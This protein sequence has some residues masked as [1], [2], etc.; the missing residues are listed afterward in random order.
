V[1]SRL[2]TNG[3]AVDVLVGS[4]VGDGIGVNV[5]IG[6]ARVGGIAVLV[7]ASVTGGAMVVVVGRGASTGAAEGGEQAVIRK[8]RMREVV[9]RFFMSIY[10]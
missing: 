9:I 3:I 5:S 7:G 2:S 6:G 1:A 4:A 8:V 10:L